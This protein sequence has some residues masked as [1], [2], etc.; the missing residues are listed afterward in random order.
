MMNFLACTG[1]VV[2]VGAAVYGVCQLISKHV[3]KQTR[4]DIAESEIRLLTEAR[5][6]AATKVAELQVRVTKLETPTS[7]PGGPT[8]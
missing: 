2:W 5:W 3:D 4:L 1:F 6:D 8:S 7:P